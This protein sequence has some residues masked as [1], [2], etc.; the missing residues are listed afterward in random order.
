MAL[1]RRWTIV[2]PLKPVPVVSAGATPARVSVSALRPHML[3]ILRSLLFRGAVAFI[4][5]PE[6]APRGEARTVDLQAVFSSVAPKYTR[7]PADLDSGAA[8]GGD[9]LWGAPEQDLLAFVRPPVLGDSSA[10][11][12]LV[13]VSWHLLWVLAMAPED[14]VSNLHSAITSA[15]GTDPSAASDAMA[16]AAVA[17]ALSKWV[18]V[19]DV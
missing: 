3:G 16:A 15:A 2:L 8:Q 10:A 19:P 6:A 1:L 17:G 5:D 7:L 4:H 11:S 14:I 12:A 9:S 13:P 18:V